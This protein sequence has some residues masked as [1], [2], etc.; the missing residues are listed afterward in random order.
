MTSVYA[1]STF[2][3]CAVS[4]CVVSSLLD[5][6]VFDVLDECC[7]SLGVS[8]FSPEQTLGALHLVPQ[9]RGFSKYW[10][11]KR[12]WLATDSWFL[13]ATA[14][15]YQIRGQKAFNPPVPITSWIHRTKSPSASGGCPCAFPT[16]LSSPGAPNVYLMPHC[17]APCS[18]QA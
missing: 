7:L 18:P 12:N 1:L 11:A 17:T 10:D 2:L 15:T 14:R 6:S 16:Y 5:F 4:L 3:T 13:I 8:A 9:L